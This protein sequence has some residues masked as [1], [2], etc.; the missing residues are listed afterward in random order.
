MGNHGLVLNLQYFNQFLHVV[1]F[2]YE[3][4]SFA[5]LM[6]EANDFLFRFDLKSGYHHVNIHPKHLKYL[7]FQWAEK[8]V[9]SY[10]VSTVLPFGLSTACFCLQS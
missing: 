9:T 2:E 1:S 3:D 10:Y 4:L 5:A 6:Y 8:G 7:G